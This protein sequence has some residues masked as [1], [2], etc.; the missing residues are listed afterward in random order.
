LGTLARFQIERIGETDKPKRVLLAGSGW[1]RE[2]LVLKRHFP[3]W[4][5][6]GFDHNKELVALGGD[7]V[8]AAGLSAA[9]AEMGSPLPFADSSFDLALSLGYFSTVFEPAARH[10]VKEVRRVTRGGIYHLED[11]RGP[12]QG[13]Q[14]KTYSL[15]AL[16]SE[17]GCESNAQPVLVDGSPIGMYLLTVAAPA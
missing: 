1:G 11:G 16:Y 15:K 14:L 3:A 2:L 10:F 17:L 8:S 12:D 5:W 13:M 7:L 9:G 6:V 4:D